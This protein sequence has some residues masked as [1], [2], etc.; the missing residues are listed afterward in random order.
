[1]SSSEIRHAT[2]VFERLVPARV[3]RVFEAFADVKL[4]TAWG[5]PTDTSVILYDESDFRV[6]GVDRYRCGNKSNPNIYATTTY[7]DIVPDKRIVLVETIDMNG[8]RLAASLSTLELALSGDQTALK[9]TVQVTSFIGDDMIKGHEQGHN[10]SLD[11]L[12]RYFQSV[13]ST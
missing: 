9:L 13:S 1:M 11:Q 5:A 6:G 7:I 8:K 3:E 12:V 2:L 10:G 4:R